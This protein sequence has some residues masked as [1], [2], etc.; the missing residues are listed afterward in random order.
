MQPPLVG[1]VHRED[2]NGRILHRR[3]CVRQSEGAIRRRSGAG[4]A[5]EVVDVGD[6]DGEGERDRA[7]RRVVEDVFERDVPCG[8]EGRRWGRGGPK[9]KEPSIASS[10]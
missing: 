10:N 4:R 8:R 1:A 3:G 6:A 7:P 5:R 9:T 2:R